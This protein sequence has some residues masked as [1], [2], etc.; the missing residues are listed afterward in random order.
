MIQTKVA[1]VG[2]INMDLVTRTDR[3]P[4]TGETLMGVAFQRFMGG[5]GANQAVAA[6]R[7]G[8]DVR[9]IGAVGDDGFG[10]EMLTNLERE[11]VF[12]QGVKTVQE[13]SS[14]MANITVSGSENTIVVVAGANAAL[15]VADI[16]EH[17]QQIAEAD[18]V[19][20]QLEIP[21]DCV[22]AAAKLAKKHGKPFVLNPAP[23]Q[24]LPQELLELVTLLTPN[25][26]ELAISLGLSQD[27]QAEELIAK[28]P[29][30]VLMTLG[31]KGAVYNDAAGRL[32]HIPSFTVNAVDST[33]AGDTFNGALAAF[34]HEGMD[35]AVRKACAAGALSVMKEGAQ[36]G[37][38]FNEELAEF[39]NGQHPKVDLGGRYD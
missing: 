31:K 18:I 20:S 16:V 29:C 33:G 4:N 35:A 32:H 26:Y 12:T 28:A 15:T 30:P 24:K 39:L 38:P 17:E 5:K 7:L 27:W 1:V 19:L 36:S 2:S 22:I 3:F 10:Y 13:V 23:A 6:A 9:M 25:A 34:W 11:G 37:M 21:M 14:G 8:A